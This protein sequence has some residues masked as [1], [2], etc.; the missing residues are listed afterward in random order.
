MKN[1]KVLWVDDETTFG[2]S[3]HF[4]IED[5]LLEKDITLEIVDNLSGGTHVWATVRDLKPDLIMMDHNLEDVIIN[6]ANL[7]AEIRHLND[8]TPIIFYSTE[9]GTTLM[10]LVNGYDRVYTST[11]LDVHSEMVRLILQEFNK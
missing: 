7:V 9:M 1:I 10:N 6:G 4:R 2:D 8:K 5:E 3:I 11:R